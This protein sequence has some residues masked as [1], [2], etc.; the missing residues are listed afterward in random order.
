MIVI[1]HISYG[2]HPPGRNS[3][4]GGPGG[5]KILEEISCTILPGELTVLLG[6]NG[7]GKSTLL[8][9]LSG[10]KKPH[11]G[12]V[13][14]DGRSIHSMSFRE[15]ALQ[16]GVL[17]Q[18]YAVNL[19]F[20]VEEVVMMGRYPHYRNSPSVND[21]RIVSESLQEMQAGHLS[22]R[23][24]NTLS[25][26]EQQRVQMARV[27]AQL[28]DQDGESAGRK[29]GMPPDRKMLLLDEPTASMDLLHQQLCL[30]KAK[31]LAEEGYTVVVVLHDLNL[32]S[33]FADRLL[34]LKTGKLLATGRP[35]DVLKP[36]LIY[37][38]Y[39]MET[40]VIYP[41][42]YNFPVIIPVLQKGKNYFQT[43]INEDSYAND[44]SKRR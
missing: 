40:A 21:K 8:R 30:R 26:G 34:L 29:E 20:T 4:P 35:S 13:L 22:G 27:L 28:R 12:S 32:A 15:L 37:T 24:F 38:V 14:W 44:Y 9:I 43:P 10:E 1:D 18:Q 31:Q 6:P 23:L 33:Q 2:G 3:V 11:T 17:T 36:D 16:R 25:G 5:R 41:S 39:G 7:A 19:P 42:S